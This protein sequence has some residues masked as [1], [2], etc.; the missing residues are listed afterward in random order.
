MQRIDDFGMHPTYNE[1][2]LV[3]GMSK[4][5]SKDKLFG[6]WFDGKRLQGVLNILITSI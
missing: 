3:S 2:G 1:N 4:L 6:L 5:H